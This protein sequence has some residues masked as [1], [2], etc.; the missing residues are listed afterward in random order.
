MKDVG[1][2]HGP[3]FRE[4]EGDIPPA[5]ANSAD[6]I[7]PPST[8]SLTTLGVFESFERLKF[9][10]GDLYSE[11]IEDLHQDLVRNLG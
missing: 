5:V 8:P 3:Q 9:L 10:D 4:R 1:V 2:D 7:P 11:H 6:F